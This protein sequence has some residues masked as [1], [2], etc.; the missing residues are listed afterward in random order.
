MPQLSFERLLGVGRI[1][2]GKGILV[3]ENSMGGGIKMREIIS[4]L[5]ETKGREMRLEKKI[6]FRS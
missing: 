3:R 1:K 2:E 4:A 6:E 5:L